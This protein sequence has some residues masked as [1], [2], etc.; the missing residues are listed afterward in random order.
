MLDGPLILGVDAATRTGLALGRPGERPDICTLNF[1]RDRTD[2]PTDIF[3]RA[4]TVMA[5]RFRDRCPDLMAI[6]EPLPGFRSHNFDATRIALGLYGIF[7][8]IAKAKGVRVL[9]APIGSW[10][11]F[12]LG[13]G[14]LKG[15]KAKAECVRLCRQ[16]GWEVPNDDHNAAEAAGIFAWACAIEAPK[17]CVRPE[18]LFV[19]TAGRAA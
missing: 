6:E 12:F 9:P 8:G 5:T 18:P 13:R 7:T 14:N 3:G 4:I 1:R 19:A 2:G 16:L 17:V 10:R 15:D 11:K